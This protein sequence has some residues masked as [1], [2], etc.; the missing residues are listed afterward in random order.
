MLSRH[1]ASNPLTTS[2]LKPSPAAAPDQSPS[3][4][5]SAI[6]A[7]MPCSA[8]QHLSCCPVSSARRATFASPLAVSIRAAWAACAKSV[9][10]R[11]IFSCPARRPCR[12]AGRGLSAAAVAL[13]PEP[14]SG[15]ARA[16]ETAARPAQGFALSPR[17]SC[18]QFHGG[19][20]YPAHIPRPACRA[21]SSSAR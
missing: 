18:R 16:R 15:D 21:S 20:Q 7:A 6:S 11:V 2:S 4:S 9:F 14:R 3:R 13:P 5:L 10:I 19:S 1:S 12:T 17:R 8:R